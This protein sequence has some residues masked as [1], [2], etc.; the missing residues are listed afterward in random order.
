MTRT[1]PTSRDVDTVLEP[2]HQPRNHRQRHI[3]QGRIVNGAAVLSHDSL[4]LRER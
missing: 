2:A 3:D 1:A 4:E